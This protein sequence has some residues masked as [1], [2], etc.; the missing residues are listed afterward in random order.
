MS[1]SLGSCLPRYVSNILSISRLVVT[2]WFARVAC[3]QV[4]DGCWI[5]DNDGRDLQIS[6]PPYFRVERRRWG[7]AVAGLL[8]AAYKDK[9]KIAHVKRTLF[10]VWT[11]QLK[12]KFVKVLLLSWFL[13]IFFD[14]L[15]V[16]SGVWGWNAR[17]PSS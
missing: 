15:S 14:W 9:K 8:W 13:L 11:A 7:I 16:S 17:H 1:T 4:D 10:N 12:L 2:G 6:A 3:L 5:W